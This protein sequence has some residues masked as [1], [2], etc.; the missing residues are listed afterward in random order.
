MENNV[1]EKKRER[2]ILDHK[3]SLRELSNFIKHSN[4]LTIGVPEKEE[5]EGGQ[6]G[7]FEQIIAEKFPNMGKE[8]DIQI[9]EAQRTPIKINK[10]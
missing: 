7:L 6:K 5:R 9:Q 4:I 2:K 1:P 3:C 10:S 8:I